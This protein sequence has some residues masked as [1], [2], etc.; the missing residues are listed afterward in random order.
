[1]LRGGV[2]GAVAHV[3]HWQRRRVCGN[4]LRRQR[5]AVAGIEAIITRESTA[6]PCVFTQCVRI[7]Q[8]RQ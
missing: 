7:D 5:C 8:Q 1:M 4:I 3:G 2:R 6:A